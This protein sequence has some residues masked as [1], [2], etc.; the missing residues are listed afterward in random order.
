M[1]PKEEQGKWEA[2]A[3]DPA[4]IVREIVWRT[5]SGAYRVCR[6]LRK[7]LVVELEVE[8]ELGE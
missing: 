8:E 2:E 5:A 4:I 6:T 3:D 1:I 7:E